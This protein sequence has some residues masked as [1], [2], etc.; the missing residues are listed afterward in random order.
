M[1]T[2]QKNLDFNQDQSEQFA[3]R[4]V[5]M[6]N[7]AALSMMISIGHRTGLFDNLD[8]LPP[9]TSSQIAEAANI[10]ERY[11]REW[12]GAMVTGRIVDYDPATQSYYLPREHARWL[13]RQFSPENIA[14]SHQ[15]TSVLGY[16]ESNVID[17]FQNGGGVHY[18]CYH[19]F[20]EVMAA[21]SAQTVVAA[22]TEHI[23]PL[24]PGL[25]DQLQ[26]GIQVLDIGCGSGKA[27]CKFA[28][29]F[30]NS[31]FT[32][33]DICEDVIAAAKAEASELN[34]TNVTFE[35]HDNTKIN[36]TNHYDL[37]TAFDVIHDQKSPA[38]VLDQV[39]DAIK[40]GGTFLMQDI[41]AS[42][43]VENN[44]EHPLG[45]FL[46]TIS[47]MHC[48]TVSLAQDGAGLG[49]VW[50]E[51]LAVKMLNDAGFTDVDVKTLDHDFINNYYIM[52]K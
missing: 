17:K 11:V 36:K 27:V 43:Y 33:Y 19:R 25:R 15:W 38:V 24:S 47:T 8:N 30:P 49:A 37:L 10:E 1:S 5:N 23:L 2:I 13:T 42:S 26:Q 41:R 3:D 52:Q 32:G 29:V 46:Y 21:E 7:E 40:P 28:Q 44:L 48:M 9:S 20:H 4:L 50:G 34:L 31:H 39:Y 14:V 16:V 35:A 45:S 51:E 18:G 12:L 6:L 22:L